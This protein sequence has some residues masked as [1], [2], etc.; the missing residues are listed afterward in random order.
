MPFSHKEEDEVVWL[1][2]AELANLDKTA[3]DFDAIQLWNQY[4]LR[5]YKD[6]TDMEAWSGITLVSTLGGMCINIAGV[7]AA[8]GME[9]PASGLRTTLSTEGI[10]EADVEWMA[11]N[12]MKVS[13]AS[14]NSHPHVFTKDEVREIYQKAL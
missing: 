7:T 4:A 3:A 2:R 6:Y 10:K 9:H 5:A 14:M 11:E 12:C 13:A 8:H 1:D